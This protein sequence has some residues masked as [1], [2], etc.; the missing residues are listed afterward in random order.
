MQRHPVKFTGSLKLKPLPIVV[1]KL[2][3]AQQVAYG[4]GRAAS[5]FGDPSSTM[6]PRSITMMRSKLFSVASRCAMAIHRPPLHQPIERILDCSLAVAVERA[7]C[8]IKQQDR[9]VL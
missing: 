1:H 2:L 5:T 9:R 4:P 8:L 3:L 6:C 7:G